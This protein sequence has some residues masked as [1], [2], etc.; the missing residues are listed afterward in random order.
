M[1]ERTDR[2]SESHVNQFRHDIFNFKTEMSNVSREFAELVKGHDLHHYMLTLMNWLSV[3]VESNVAN[4]SSES[5]TA[6]IKQGS[7]SMNKEPTAVWLALTKTEMCWMADNTRSDDEGSVGVRAETPS[8][9]LLQVHFAD[10]DDHFSI[11]VHNAS[12]KK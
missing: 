4:V 7:R 9:L 3:L 5:L 1:F 2:T 10:L 8:S 12:N 6:E 11:P